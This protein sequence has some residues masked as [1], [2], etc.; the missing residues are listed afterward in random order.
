MGL[1]LTRTGNQRERQ[2]EYV[3]INEYRQGQVSDKTVLRD[4]DLPPNQIFMELTPA[5]ITHCMEP[6][7][8]NRNWGRWFWLTLILLIGK[9]QSPAIPRR[10]Q[11]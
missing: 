7:V 6:R 4:I 9:A 2:P 3:A 10:D 11:D 5:W 8:F 1:R